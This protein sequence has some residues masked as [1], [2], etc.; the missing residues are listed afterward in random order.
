MNMQLMLDGLKDFEGRN[1]KSSRDWIVF[2]TARKDVAGP[3]GWVSAPGILPGH[4]YV[5][6]YI[7]RFEKGVDYNWHWQLEVYPITAPVKCPPVGRGRQSPRAEHADAMRA[8]VVQLPYMQILM[9]RVWEFFEEPSAFVNVRG[10]MEIPLEMIQCYAS[11]KYKGWAQTCTTSEFMWYTLKHKDPCIAWGV[12]EGTAKIQVKVLGHMYV[13]M[14]PVRTC[15]AF[16]SVGVCR[17]LDVCICA[18]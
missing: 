3:L 18:C 10:T 8:L 13:Q 17:Q 16:V 1:K 12:I 4:I 14:H 9:S 2:V 7:T 5:V 15:A 11:T 6:A